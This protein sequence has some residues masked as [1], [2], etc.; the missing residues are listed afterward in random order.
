MTDRNQEELNYL[1]LLKAILERG[2]KRE[3]RTGVGTLSLFGTRLRF[4]LSDGTLPLITTK[5]VFWRGSVEELLFFIAGK[6]QT[7]ELEAKG[8][9]IWK[10]NST[11]EFQTA[12]GLSHYEEGDIGEMYGWNWRKF[13][14]NENGEGGIDQLQ[15][16]FDLIKKD[17]TSRRIMVN[18]HNPH[19][20]HMGVLEPCH[21]FYQFYVDDGKLSCQ[22]Y[23]R[24][25]DIFLGFPLNLCSY[26]LLTHMMAKATGLKPGELIF[27]GGDTHGY[28]SHIEQIKEQMKREP[29]DFPKINIKKDIK[30]IKDME[31]MVFED[32]E[33]IDYKFHPAIKAPMAI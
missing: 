2:S 30:S 13:G 32:F 3:D 11:K 29:F 20:S 25:V 16:A 5:K 17:P 33:L 18:A 7:K 23:Q 6:R 28:L 9:N 27:V 21:A 1:N 19:R 14:A 26:A 4:D 8:V 22:W 15:N 31:H 10:G 12:R 24:S